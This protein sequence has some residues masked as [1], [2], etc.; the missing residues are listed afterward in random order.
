MT[1]TGPIAA[2]RNRL[3]ATSAPTS[4]MASDCR[5]WMESDIFDL[6]EPAPGPPRGHAKDIA[7]AVPNAEN[8]GKLPF[9]AI[10][11]LNVRF[12]HTK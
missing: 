8:G 1:G 12:T 7:G 2:E 10:G 11:Q 6:L 9:P 3:E 5:L 4:E